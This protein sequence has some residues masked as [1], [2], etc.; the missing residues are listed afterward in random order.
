M[1]SRRHQS[2]ALS[3]CCEQLEL[4]FATVETVSAGSA[5]KFCRLAEGRGDI[6][7]RFSP[8]SEWD[9]AAGQALLEAAGGRVV[10]MAFRPLRYNRQRS[11]ASP[12]FYALAGLGVAWESIL[13]PLEGQ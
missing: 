4:H 9:T 6:Y 5:L 3:R 8:C 12:H 13:A 11:V 7:P 10:D 2:K 1:A